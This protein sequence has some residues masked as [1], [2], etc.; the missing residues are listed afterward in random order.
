MWMDVDWDARATDFPVLDTL[1]F[2]VMTI[3]T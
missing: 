2:V 3:C 1:L